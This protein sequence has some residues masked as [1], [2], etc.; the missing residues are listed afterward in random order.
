MP[1]TVQA[2]SL[3]QLSFIPN[4]RTQERERETSQV[5]Q[6]NLKYV[7]CVKKILETLLILS[8]QFLFH[9]LALTC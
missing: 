3:L 4:F 2:A 8:A 1:T 7:S 9:V 5:T 6:C